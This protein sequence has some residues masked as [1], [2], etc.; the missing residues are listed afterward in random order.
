MTALDL[1]PLTVDCFELADSFEEAE[2]VAAAFLARYNGRTLDA[3][4]HDLRTFFQW[5]TDVGLGVLEANR[6]HIELYRSALEQ[7]GLAASTVD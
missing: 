6:P 7:R 3:N 5:A 1:L 2:L 4:R